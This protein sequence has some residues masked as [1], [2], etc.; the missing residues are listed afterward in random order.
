MAKGRA[1]MTL[2]QQCTAEQLTEQLPVSA[3]VTAPQGLPSAAQLDQQLSAVLEVGLPITLS[4]FGC[5]HTHCMHN[6]Q[7]IILESCID[8]HQHGPTWPHM[9]QLFATPLLNMDKV[10][11]LQYNDHG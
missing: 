10:V 11:E 3:S 8:M 6:R 5:S 9:G 4:G 2:L 7:Q 1:D